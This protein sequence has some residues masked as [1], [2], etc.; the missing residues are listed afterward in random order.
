LPGI[1]KDAQANVIGF[2]TRSVK[3]R[4]T[5]NAAQL[6]RCKV[7]QASPETAYRGSYC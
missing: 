5:G 6:C 3:S 1:A 7:L 4:T 2:D